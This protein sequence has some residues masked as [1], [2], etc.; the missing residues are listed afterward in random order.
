MTFDRA[1]ITGATSGIGEAL[2]KKLASH[3]ISLLLTGRNLK[4][5][6]GLKTLLSN[7]VSV[8]ILH[9]D[10]GSPIERKQ[11][12][13]W[14]HLKNP[15]LLINNAG[16]GLYGNAIEFPVDEQL[17][18]LEVDVNAVVE[19]TLEMSKNLI[20]SG[21]QGVILNVSSAAAY[22]IF[23]QFTVYAAAKAFLNSFSCSLDYELKSQ[24]VR[25]LAACPGQVATDFFKRASQG[26]ND[27]RSKLL[28]MDVEEAAQNIWWQ[29][30]NGKP[31]YIFDWKYRLITYLSFFFPKS[32]VASILGRMI[33]KRK[34][35]NV[36][37]S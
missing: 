23:P 2:A 30:Q 6:N 27:K 18:M 22:Q 19:L 35:S 9:L 7:L 37:S 20:A 25:I 34:K 15:D 10:L 17:K 13:A 1:L 32:W 5:L 14:I 36:S 16:Y 26:S 21:K 11:L 24:G 8:E 29:I 12:L 28:V 3:G 31:I 4:K 33:A